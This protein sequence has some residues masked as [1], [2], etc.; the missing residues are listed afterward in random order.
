LRRSSSTTAE[1]R[2]EYFAYHGWHDSNRYLDA[3]DH[4]STYATCTLRRILYSLRG[5]WDA[6]LQQR[7]RDATGVSCQ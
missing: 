6:I 2:P 1:F 3:G 5:S 7:I 4:C